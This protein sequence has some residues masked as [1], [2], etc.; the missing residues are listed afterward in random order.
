MKVAIVGAGGVGSYYGGLLAEAGH[1][2]SFLAR[3]AHLEALRS[4]GLE[5]RTPE[6]RFRVSVAATDDDA[7]L[8]SPD[9]AIV[10]VKGYSLEEVAPALRRLADRSAVIVPLLNGVEAVERLV[11]GG[12]PADALLDGLTTISVVRSAPGEV[13]RRSPFQRIVVGEPG[14]GASSRA[15]R[16]AAPFRK[17]GVEAVVS[18][19]IRTEVWRKFVFISS[20]AA[21][22]GL[23]RS[24]IGPIRETV[25]GAALIE[26]AV[27]EV[28][29]VARA[30]GAALPPDEE[31]R[32][33]AFFR[34]LPAAMKPSFLLDLEAGGRTEIDD[35]SGA[36][37]RLAA[38]SG[39]A[40]PVHD[41]A[42]AAL[43]AA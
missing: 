7:A 28:A 8:G 23:A 31:S 9:F 22:C 38:A 1:E 26:R 42:A 33:V 40:T 17:C 4:R 30:Q 24:A 21:V 14:G 12:V 6:S 16:F 18:E 32:I 11:R 37:S 2:V 20:M 35:L 34:S 29:A 19:D 10:A 36:V 25:R 5:V 15:E 3:G 41:T 13:E 43:G 39:V 27:A